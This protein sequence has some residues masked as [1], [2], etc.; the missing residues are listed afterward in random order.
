[1][2]NQHFSQKI[3][4]DNHKVIRLEINLKKNKLE[5][6]LLQCMYVCMARLTSRMTAQTST[7][8]KLF[9]QRSV[10]TAPCTVLCGKKGETLTSSSTMYP[11]CTIHQGSTTTQSTGRDGSSSFTG[12]RRKNF[13]TTTATSVNPRTFTNHKVYEPKYVQL[14]NTLTFPIEYYPMFFIAA[15]TSQTVIEWVHTWCKIPATFTLLDNSC[16]ER[17]SP[18]MSGTGSWCQ[19]THCDQLPTAVNL[20]TNTP[21]DY[22]SQCH[23]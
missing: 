11:V 19:C 4:T 16:Q 20:P 6:Q 21:A 18:L 3:T 5:Q 7:S 12:R 10:L 23:C 2:P 17:K 14:E 13:Y 1:M 8:N 9:P 22:S 15:K